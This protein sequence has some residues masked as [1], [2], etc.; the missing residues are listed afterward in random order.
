VRTQ[1][2]EGPYLKEMMCTP[3]YYKLSAHSSM[4]F[5]ESWS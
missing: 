4:M 2:S 5:P 1:F 3:A